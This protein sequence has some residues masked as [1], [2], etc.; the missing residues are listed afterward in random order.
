MSTTRPFKG[1]NGE[2]RL[3][4]ETKQGVFELWPR[5]VLGNKLGCCSLNTKVD[6]QNS[7]HA[8][9]IWKLGLGAVRGANP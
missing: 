6:L 9:D 5:K 4:I 3:G 7:Q 8:V 1:K 2:T